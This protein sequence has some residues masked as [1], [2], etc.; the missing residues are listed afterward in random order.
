MTAITPQQMRELAHEGDERALEI[1]TR[2]PGMVYTLTAA[3]RSAADQLE[4]V[5]ANV[6]ALVNEYQGDAETA[7]FDALLGELCILTAD[8]APQEDRDA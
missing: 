3:L 5:R 6:K 4:A 7:R 1:L 8:T 2:S